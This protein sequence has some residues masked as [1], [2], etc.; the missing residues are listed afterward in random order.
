MEAVVTISTAVRDGAALDS[1]SARRLAAEGAKE[2]AR[3]PLAQPTLTLGSDAVRISLENKNAQTQQTKEQPQPK[4][5]DGTLNREDAK[6]LAERLEDTM[7][8]TEVKF[9]VSVEGDAGS[10][11]R[12]VV[13]DKRS[14]EVVR[15][16]PP[17]E[18]RALKEKQEEL[19]QETG[20]LIQTAA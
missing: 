3:K 9:S 4:K 20:V 7:N 15:E 14:G 11:M 19:Q 5:S 12:F 2:V 18:A 10:T 1:S 13:L 16:F 6:K 17:E 8:Q